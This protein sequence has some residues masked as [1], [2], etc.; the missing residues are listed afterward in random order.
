M[1]TPDELVRFKSSYSGN[2]GTECVEVAP[3]PAYANPS[4]WAARPSTSVPRPGWRSRVPRRRR[5]QP[6]SVGSGTCGA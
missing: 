3:P 6:Q 5:C 2:E 4:T 1:N